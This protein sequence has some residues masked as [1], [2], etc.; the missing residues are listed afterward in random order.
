MKRSQL[1]VALYAVLTFASGAL[2]GIVG[3]RLYVT[4]GAREQPGRRSPDDFRRRYIEEMRSRLKLDDQ[5]VTKLEG[6]LDATRDRIRQVRDKERPEM[7]AIQEEQRSRI[8][9]MLNPAQQAEYAKM[10]E[11]REKRT[12]QMKGPPGRH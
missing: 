8:R 2:V 3:H 7:D 10:L 1:A 9:A 4:A 5:Q 12:R 6:I 11:E